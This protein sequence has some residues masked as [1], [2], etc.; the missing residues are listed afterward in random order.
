MAESMLLA[1]AGIVVLGMA[2]EWLAWRIHLPTIF[3]LL[4]F[5]VVA[6]PLTGQLDPDRIF[7]GLLMPLVSLS[8]AVILFEGGLTLRFRELRAVGRVVW[9]LITAGVLITWVLAAL[10]AWFFLGFDARLAALLGAILVVTGPTVVMPLLAHI[11]PRGH[12]AS[13]LKWEGITVDPVGATL[14]VLVFEALYEHSGSGA[15]LFVALGVIR[16]VVIGCV[17]G[18]IGVAF[19][20]VLLR[21]H[22]LPDHLHSPVSLAVVLGAFALSNTIQH[23][24]GLLTVTLLGAMLANQRYVD[25]RHVVEFEENLRVLLLSSLF[26]ILSARLDMDRLT[27]LGMG[28]VLFLGALILVVRP[29][30]VLACTIGSG[31]NWRE[32]TFLAYLAPRGVVAAAVTSVFA[33]RLAEDGVARADELVPVTFFAIAGLVALYAV[34]ARPVARM[35]G[36]ALPDPTGIVIVG[37]H[38]LGRTIG[39]A[40]L[41]EGFPVLV[42]DRNWGNLSAARMEGLATYHG[43]VLSEHALHETD[44]SEMGRL[45]A[46]TANDEINSL[47]ALHFSEEFG[48]TGVYQLAVEGP[49]APGTDTKAPAPHLRGQILF[50]KDAGYSTLAR[51]IVEGATVKATKVSEKFTYASFREKYGEAA[52]PLFVIDERGRLRVVTAG[53][54]IDPQPGDKIIALVDREPET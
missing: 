13:I 32:R 17:L 33:L 43:D 53:S 44:L 54:A 7:G 37:G 28:S 46:L 21:K 16:T 49:T 20:V 29:A 10:A 27:G 4:L 23:E 2:A 39:K 30:A 50:G 9:L 12:V 18:G 36:L 52:T 11:R 38:R 24:S 25:I 41:A 42:I 47:A 48:K 45:F 31:L 8:V 40:L 14:A 6:G 22:W 15:T 35:L 34:T 5:G 19:L 26:I 3:V 51:R 1:L